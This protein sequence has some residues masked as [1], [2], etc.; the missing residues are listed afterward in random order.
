[1]KRHPL[2]GTLSFS[3]VFVLLVG[4]GAAA[5]RSRSDNNWELLGR[6]QVDFKRDRDRIEVGKKEGRFKALEIR[7][8][9]APVEIEDMVVTFG[10]GETFKPGIRHRFEEG[11]RSKAIDLPGDRRT[12]S[13]IDFNYR[14]VDRR[15]GKA[16]VAVYAR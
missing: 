3:L 15:D 5:Q 2:I 9:G 8:E 4:L 16:T 13:R 12:I 14:S 10:N 6:K 7:V 1:M 11:S